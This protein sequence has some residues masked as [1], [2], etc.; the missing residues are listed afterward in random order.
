MRPVVVSCAQASRTAWPNTPR[1]GLLYF[2][3]DRLDPETDAVCVHGG[4]HLGRNWS[5]PQ[6]RDTLESTRIRPE[7]RGEF[8]AMGGM[9]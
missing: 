2:R 7:R 4:S 5:S 8:L 3:A 6:A 9:T 1:G